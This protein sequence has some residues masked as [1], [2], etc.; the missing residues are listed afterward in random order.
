MLS[1]NTF[2][3][4]AEQIAQIDRYRS[5][6]EQIA[7]L[8]EPIDR[9][10]EKL[11]INQAYNLINL[12][13]PNTLFF[14]TP[15]EA[16]DYLNREITANW[17][18]L[19]ESFFGK[20]VAGDLIDKLIGNIRKEIKKELLEQ[21]QGNLDSGLADSIALETTARLQTNRIFTIIMANFRAMAIASNQESNADAF[22]NLLFELF[23][24]AGFVVNNFILPP[25]WQIE[26]LFHKDRV[27]NTNNTLATF[28]TGRF[29][30]PNSTRYELPFVDANSRFINVIIPSV[31]TDFAYYIDYCHEV[32][33]CDRDAQKWDVFYNLITSCG[34]L[35]PYENIVLIC[36][37]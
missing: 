23:L 5:K 34:W 7:V 36:D 10:R 3:F 8:K 25:L 19:N 1:F 4:T 21:L 33:N 17:G 22:N 13:E 24:E 28:L 11:A 20:P 15:Y 29:S 6:W 9:E 37:R 12:S 31:M 35:F 16:L 30:R 18:K 27:N 32:L 26:N 14:A 2:N